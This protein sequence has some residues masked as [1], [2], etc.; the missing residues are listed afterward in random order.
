VK[1][2]LLGL[3]FG[4]TNKGCE[5]LG[6]G[7]LN[8]LE[9]LAERHQTIIEVVLFYNYDVKI[10]YEN[11]ISERVNLEIV[12]LPGI[13]SISH[14][15]EHI[16]AYKEC[17]F[18]FDFTAGDSFSDIYGMERFI[19]RT[20]VKN[21]VIR[22]DT[23]LIL[24]SQTYGPYKSLYAKKYARYIL[25]KS[26]KVFARDDLSLKVVKDI[27][28]VQAIRTVDVAFAMGYT[29]NVM[30]SE[31]I[32]V[33]FNPSG[34]L[35]Q[36]GYNKNNQFGLKV[37]YQKYCCEVILK[38][39]ANP[40]YCVY[41]VPHVLSNNLE[42]VDNDMVACVELIKKYPQLKM[43]SKFTTPVEAKSFISGLSVF[44]GARM[45]ATIA[46][47][48]T[49]VP[50]IPFSYSPKFEGLFSSLNYKHIILGCKVDT[51]KAIEKTFNLLENY[52]QLKGELDLLQIE[53]NAGIENLI[54]ETEKIIFT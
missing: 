28:G 47:F 14:L 36:G 8:V 15:K 9:T 3:A 42:E 38:L 31:K 30:D 35:W 29:K 39:L 27:S 49:N 6:Y 4:S 25:K 43:A 20:V 54:K 1:I 26:T 23:P 19:R 16:N 11:G 45:H 41:L 46:A 21:L 50:V 18:V 24:G 44:I 13:G 2:G 51:E 17:D 12:S 34:L 32:N 10:L 37:D 52:Q 48:T 33:G 53:I 5:A 22:S 7:F 40:K